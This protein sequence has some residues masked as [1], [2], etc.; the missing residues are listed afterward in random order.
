MNVGFIGLGNM[1]QP[2]ARNLLRAGHQLQVYNRTPQRAQAL[3]ADGAVP[4]DSPAS[5]ATG[6]DVVITMLA[7]D[8]AVE[9]AV[10]GE[11]GLLDTLAPG[12]THLSM[13]T[14]SV[15]LSRRL[16]EAHA[17][18]GQQ[19]LSA[20]VFGRPDAAAAGMLWI[21]AAGPP[22][23]MEQCR[24]LLEAVG[25]GIVVVGEEPEAAN[26]VKLAGNFLFASALE[27]MAESFA[28]IRKYGID[29]NQFLDLVG[30]KLFR[31]PTYQNYGRLIAEAR[32]EP[33]GFKMRYGAKDT[34][35]VLQAAESQAV[36]MPLAS[37]VHE[38]Y[39]SG[40]ARGWGDIDWSSL[41]RVAA[42]NAGLDEGRV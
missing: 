38:N 8:A 39:V 41:G 13:S 27:A 19:Y 15:A 21:V 22:A 35:F 18:A 40:I 37:L 5:A 33:V 30:E 14:N 42:A 10:F 7:D 26:V 17:R 25:Q 23:T 36:P 29:T 24:P 4:V 28:L 3:A 16:A 12:T 2:M 34:R 6:V 1:G 9:G 31:S 20:P 32:Y 11:Y